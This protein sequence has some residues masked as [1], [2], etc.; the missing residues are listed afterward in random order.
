[1]VANRINAV[2]NLVASLQETVLVS[3]QKGLV[4]NSLYYNI[5]RSNNA[6]SFTTQHYLIKVY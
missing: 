1:M 6:S 3:A 5:N 2:S 4:S